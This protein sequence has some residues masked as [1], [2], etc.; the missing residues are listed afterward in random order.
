MP[1]VLTRGKLSKGRPKV[2]TLIAA[3][4]CPG[5]A[6]LCADS[7]ETVNVD[8]ID[9]RM[10][11]Q[12]VTPHVTASCQMT[13]AG[14]GH[15]D[16]I[17]AFVIRVERKLDA[18]TVGTIAEVQALI[19]SELEDFYARD[20]ALCPDP[21]EEKRVK[22]F[23][24]AAIPNAEY[25]VWVTEGIRLRPIQEHELNGHQEP[26]Y[27]ATAKRLYSSGM[28]IAQAILA[29]IYVLTIAEE[30]SNYVR[31]PMSVAVIDKHG[32]WM[33]DEHYVETVRRRLQQYERDVNAI[34]LA[35][36]DTGLSVDLL[37]KKIEA[38]SESAL[39]LHRQHIDELMGSMSVEELLGRREP[40]AKRPTGSV[41]NVFAEPPYL[42]I[43][44]DS[45]KNRQ[46]IEGFRRMRE[47]GEQWIRDG[48]KMLVK[49]VDCPHPDCGRQFM[50]QAEDTGEAQ[51]K[52]SAQ[53]F[54]CKK[55][56]EVVWNRPMPSDTSTGQP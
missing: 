43:E 41:V 27:E 56:V 20:V 19:E 32:I 1:P 13:L 42:R 10:S 5:A 22:L 23:I 55:P 26:L 48:R 34:F 30:T 35:C 50:T 7:Q 44:H 29:S 15:A 21:P 33:E 40:Y 3:K 38:F 28:T 18:I 12:K 31:G 6:I 11:V 54:H 4:R 37:R 39:A 17:E 16:L 47:Q 45:E 14:S 2:V 53:C 51:V 36:A 24:A 25:E 46:A 49:V 9:Y 8:G 52:K